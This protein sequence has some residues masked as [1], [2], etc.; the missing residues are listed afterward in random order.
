MQIAWLNS[1]AF[2]LDSWT[3]ENGSLFTNCSDEHEK[4]QRASSSIKKKDKQQH[5]K[6]GEQSILFSICYYLCCK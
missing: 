4:K 3:A 5:E 1:D 6:R 2:F